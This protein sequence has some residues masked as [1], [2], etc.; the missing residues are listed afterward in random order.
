[1][2]VFGKDSS[3]VAV[4]SLVMLCATSGLISVMPE[5]IS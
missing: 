2:V 3:S 1:M 4:A 5:V